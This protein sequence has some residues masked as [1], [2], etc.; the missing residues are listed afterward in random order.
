MESIAGNCKPSARAKN[1]ISSAFSRMD[2][3][4]HCLED[5]NRW[6]FENA[7]RTRRAED[8]N[9]LCSGMSIGTDIDRF[10]KNQSDS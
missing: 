1:A 4:D 3:C 6:N 10:V 5:R 7:P 2:E 8:S 9:I